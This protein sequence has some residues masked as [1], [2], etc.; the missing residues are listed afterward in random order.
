MDARVRS[1]R[2]RARRW[3]RARLQRGARHHGEIGNAAPELLLPAPRARQGERGLAVRFAAESEIDLHRL[4]RAR[5]HDRRQR[6]INALRGSETC[7]RE[8]RQYNG[9]GS[10]RCLH[11]SPRFHG[12]AA[13]AAKRCKPSRDAGPIVRWS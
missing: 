10:K 3:C 7:A 12:D 8:K 4:Q 13:K 5:A 6:V 11:M 1:M 2:E 9:D